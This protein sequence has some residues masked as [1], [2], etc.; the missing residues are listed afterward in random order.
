M[1]R[2][3]QFLENMVA[4]QQFLSERGFFF[5]LK[6]TRFG[7]G[8][9]CTRYKKMTCGFP[10]AGKALKAIARLSL[11]QN[12]SENASVMTGE[13]KPST[14]DS[15]KKKR[16]RKKQTSDSFG[17]ELVYSDSFIL[18][19]LRW[20]FFFP[21]PPFPQLSSPTVWNMRRTHWLW[22][23]LLGRTGAVALKC[24]NFKY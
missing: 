15:D 18:P 12:A 23:G 11:A 21:L 16:K 22:D 17:P 20:S 9:T 3:P 4:Y 7:V 10:P 24:K 6:P 14:S 1:Q 13:R 5:S 2:L 8:Q 19:Q